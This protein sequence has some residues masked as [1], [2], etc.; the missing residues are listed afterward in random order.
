M[1]KK[2]IILSQFS[3]TVFFFDFSSRLTINH[4]SALLSGRL[5]P[6]PALPKTSATTAALDYSAA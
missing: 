4:F 2:C 6:F 5:S 1:L 3:E